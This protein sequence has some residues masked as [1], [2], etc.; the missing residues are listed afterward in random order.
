MLY[1]YKILTIYKLLDCFLGGWPAISIFFIVFCGL[2]S[3][4]TS[5]FSALFF[6]W[7]KQRGVCISPPLFYV[8]QQGM[9]FVPV[10]FLLLVI[11]S[12]IK[13]I[14]IIK[15]TSNTVPYLKFHIAL[16]L[17]SFI[18][19][20]LQWGISCDRV[21]VYQLIYSHSSFMFTQ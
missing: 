17:S 20:Y 2:P 5:F 19:H 14:I 11:N 7:R 6:L 15:I 13:R 4:T 8:Q 1:V 18:R 12:T 21:N 16:Q 3:L 9:Y 10:I